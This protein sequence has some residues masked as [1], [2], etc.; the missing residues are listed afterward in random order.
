M[1]DTVVSV[2]CCSFVL[3]ASSDLIIIVKIVK[4]YRLAF[5]EV[6]NRLCHKKIKETQPV[7]MI[8]QQAMVTPQE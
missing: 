3:H 6:W 2:A 7:F 4:P 8:K 1:P 5:E